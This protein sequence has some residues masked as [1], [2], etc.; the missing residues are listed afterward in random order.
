MGSIWI[1]SP[2]RKSSEIV[3]PIYRL[4]ITLW[5]FIDLTVFLRLDPFSSPSESCIEDLSPAFSSESDPPIFTS[6]SSTLDLYFFKLAAYSACAASIS[7]LFLWLYIAYSLNI[8]YSSASFSILAVS[9]AEASIKALIVFLYWTSAKILAFLIA[10]IPDSDPFYLLSPVENSFLRYSSLSW[11]SC[12]F[13][14]LL[15]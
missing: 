5:C 10:C 7:C 8:F 1:E 4:L 9:T 6:S 3:S 12:C 15:T 14:L 11:S 13:N 2:K